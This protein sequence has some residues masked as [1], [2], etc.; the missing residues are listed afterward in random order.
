MLMNKRVVSFVVSLAILAVP[1]VAWMQRDAIFDAWRL[2]NY[3]APAEVVR[4]ADAT[5][6]TSDSRRLF[7]VYHPALAD[8][9]TFN[10]VCTDS[11]QTIVLGCYVQ[12]RG[13]YLYNVA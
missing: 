4:L 12:H 13:I 1:A 9:S 7:Y 5:T 8:K 10:G 6:M 11:E 2:R 3:S